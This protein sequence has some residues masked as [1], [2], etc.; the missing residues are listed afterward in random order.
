MKHLGVSNETT[1][2][3]QKTKEEIKKKIDESLVN[4][5]TQNTDAEEK[6]RMVG[7]REDTAN[8]CQEFETIIRSNKKIIVSL[9]YHQGIIFRKSEHREYSQI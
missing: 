1:K 9:A 4:E 2:S 5:E 6:A 7:K 3:N 8:V